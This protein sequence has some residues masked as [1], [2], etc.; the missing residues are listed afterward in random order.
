MRCA[1]PGH[2]ASVG[3]ARDS[4]A[5]DGGVV[6]PNSLTDSLR[7]NQLWVCERVA[8]GEWQALLNFEP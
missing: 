8:R 1:S 7:Q 3:S 6:M 5:S 4:D 2:S